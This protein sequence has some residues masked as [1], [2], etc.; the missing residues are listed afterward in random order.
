MKPFAV[1]A[2]LAALAVP[3]TASAHVEVLP[4]SVAPRTDQEMTIQVP[5]ERP[6]A[7]TRV[8]VIFPSGLS[9]FSIGRTPGWHQR[10]LL[11]KDRRLRGVVYSGGRIDPSHY[12]TFRVLGAGARPGIFAWRVFQAYADGKVKPWTAAPERGGATE[13]ETGPTQP[14][15]SPATRVAVLAKAALAQTSPQQATGAPR[16]SAR[17][18]AP[19]PAKSDAGIWLGVIGIA[20]S[21]LA[22]V[23]VGLLWSTRPAQL[24]GDEEFCVTDEELAQLR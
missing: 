17:A 21:T 20:I 10:V 3:S 6:V 14:G 9:V 4:A 11:T 5:N 13:T 15:P 18:A 23:L 16:A 12:E 24:P 8:S 1:L 22:I 2:A 7:T 19:A